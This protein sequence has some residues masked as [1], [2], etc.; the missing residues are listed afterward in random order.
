MPV[1]LK[2][3]ITAAAVNHIFLYK[4]E[5]CIPNLDVMENS[6]GIK[7]HPYKILNMEK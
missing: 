6:I 5:V 2:F 4:V 3:G 1:E 7:T